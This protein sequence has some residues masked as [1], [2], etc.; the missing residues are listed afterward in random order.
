MIR[1]ADWLHEEIA[2]LAYHFHWPPDVLLDL[3]HRDRLRYV[4]EVGRI[5]TRINQGG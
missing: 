3:V 2:Y 5:N 1:P 4:A